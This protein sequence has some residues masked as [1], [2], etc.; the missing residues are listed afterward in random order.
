MDTAKGF[1]ELSGYCDQL[2]RAMA[3]IDD[4]VAAVQKAPSMALGLANATLFLDAA[5]HAVIAWMWLKQAVAALNGLERNNEADKAFYT[6]KLA[7]CQFFY[8]YELPKIDSQLDLVASL[9]STCLDLTA[10]Q[11]I[12]K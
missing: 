5:G 8:R 7:A 1:A 12:G 11:F 4:T 2:R 3:K 10:D 6:G 9:D